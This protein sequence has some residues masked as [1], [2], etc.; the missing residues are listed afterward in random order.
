M[1]ERIDASPTTAVLA[2]GDA[3]LIALFVL[4]G[5]LRHYPPGRALARAPGTAIQFY[6][7]WAVVAVA[8][9]AY[10][11]R[12]RA[13]V[14]PAVTYAVGAWVGAV[15]VAMAL[16]ATAVFQG[17][18]SPAFFAVALLVGAVL[19]GAWRGAFAYRTD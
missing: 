12:A 16:R 4:A 9:G 17:D 8:V 11:V 6:I 18:F 5:E 7:G 19:L 3:V 1:S 10:A 15:V 2:A 14:R 13:G